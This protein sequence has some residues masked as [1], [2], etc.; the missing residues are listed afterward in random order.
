MLLEN[1]AMFCKIANEKSISKV[2]QANH[3]S[4]PALSQQMQRLEEELGIKLLERSNRGI[5]LTAAGQIMQKY[6]ALFVKDYNNLREEIDNLKASSATFRIAASPV[7]CNYALP[8]ILYKANQRFPNYAF[9]LSDY[10]SSEVV[11]QVVNKQA[12]IGFIVGKTGHETLIETSAFVDKIY[13]IAKSSY[14]IKPPESIKDVRKFPLIMLNSNFSSYR[15]VCNYLKNLGCPIEGFNV[16]YSLNTTEALKNSVSAGHGVAFLPYMAVKKE[17]FT[18]EFKIIEIPGF[19][20]NYDIYSVY[21]SGTE[22][23]D[24][25][26]REIIQYLVTTVKKY[27]C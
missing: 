14:H 9:S 23:Y 26:S 12:D 1:V 8:C 22:N 4:Q 7:I 25:P 6:A 21:R 16:S 11:T 17:I 13:L 5:E 20:L 27:I 2:A 24:S 10:H 18:S 19:D 15:L 3:I